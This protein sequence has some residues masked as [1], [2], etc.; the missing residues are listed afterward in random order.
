MVLDQ[1]G[2]LLL[3]DQGA[4]AVVGVIARVVPL[5]DR[6]D[7]LGFNACLR[8]IVDAA[9][10][11]AVG[12]Y[13]DGTAEQTREHVCPPRERVPSCGYPFG[14]AGNRRGSGVPRVPRR[15]D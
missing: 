11:V 14:W 7:R 6:L 9:R 5:V 10:Q 12:G 15:F 1:L 2:A 4:G 13:L 8:G 3:D